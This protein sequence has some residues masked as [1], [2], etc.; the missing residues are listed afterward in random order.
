MDVGPLLGISV[1]T[2]LALVWPFE[3]GFGHTVDTTSSHIPSEHSWWWAME[4]KGFCNRLSW[5]WA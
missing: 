1:P 5:A 2:Q 3:P 4:E